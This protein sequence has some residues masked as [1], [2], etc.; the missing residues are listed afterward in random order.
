MI[1]TNSTACK[2]DSRINDVI[3][4]ITYIWH[5]VFGWHT[6]RMADLNK[7]TE[8]SQR[9]LTSWSIFWKRFHTRRDGLFPCY[10]K[11]EKIILFS[12]K[13]KRHFYQPCGNI[14]NS[15]WLS[16]KR[17]GSTHTTPPFDICRITRTVACSPTQRKHW[18]LHQFVV[19]PFLFPVSV[20]LTLCTYWDVL[21]IDWFN[22]KR[23]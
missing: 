5:N 6:I 13:I 9:K 11:N 17:F 10:R 2:S 4:N 1:S 3:T 14:T 22:R 16:I 19:K 21:L 12:Q 8:R 15:I 20:D 7:I 18:K 23:V